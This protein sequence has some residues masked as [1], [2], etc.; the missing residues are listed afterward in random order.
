MSDWGKGVI[1]NIGWG[2]G[3]NNDIGWGSIYD[4][5]NA[6]ETLLSVGF[7]GFLNKFSGASLG[8]SLDKLDKNYTGSAI[9]VRRSSDNNELDI[10]FVN[11]ELDTASLLDF[12]G[13]GNGFV[14]IWYDQSGEGNNLLQT[15]A[16]SQPQIVSNGSLILENGKPCVDFL[17]LRFM[18][19]DSF[20]AGEFPYDYI[21]YA[22]VS[23]KQPGKN[24]IYDSSNR[25]ALT[26]DG[27]NFGAENQLLKTVFTNNGV[28]QNNVLQNGQILISALQSEQSTLHINN[29][30]KSD[31]V[32]EGNNDRG[33]FTDL[34]LGTRI[35]ATK[36]WS[37]NMQEII[38]F[39][40]GQ[41]Q[42]RIQ[43]Q[44]NINSRY[45]IY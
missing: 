43:A 36:I 40:S 7:E 33:S 32:I 10:G 25:H 34:F 37:G 16:S 42:Q 15:L 19:L 23:Q 24:Y 4:K 9:K 31:I 44:N 30:D 6:G 26:T 13:S 1:N 22:V 27:F 28:S 38:I 20:Q 3:A 12:V 5:S 21:T 35:S 18:A 8:L 2:Q 14:S 41:G 11:N 39:K 17:G 45:N 29:V